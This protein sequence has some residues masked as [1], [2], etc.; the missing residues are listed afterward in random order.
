MIPRRAGRTKP[1]ATTCSGLRRCQC[2]LFAHQDSGERGTS[3]IPFQVR[4]SSSL[5]NWHKRT[6][7]AI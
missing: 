4:T 7:I 3:Q 1:T 6:S 2:D 5:Q